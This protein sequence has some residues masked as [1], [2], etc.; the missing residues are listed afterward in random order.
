MELL[1]SIYY[2]EITDIYDHVYV[3]DI[4][5]ALKIFVC[6]HVYEPTP[7]I[8]TISCCVPHMGP[9]SSMYRQVLLVTVNYCLCS[10]LE[11][12]MNLYQNN[13]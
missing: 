11:C 6:L 3:L 4:T 12:Q 13:L 7:D 5:L 8:V 9:R 1:E 2:A 10:R